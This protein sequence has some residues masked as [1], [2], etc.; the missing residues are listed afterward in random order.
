[1][2]LRVDKKSHLWQTQK[3]VHKIIFVHLAPSV[4]F[5]INRQ[6]RQ[7]QEKRKMAAILKIQDILT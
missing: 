2:K 7:L 1:M 3:N 5:M 4:K 6:E